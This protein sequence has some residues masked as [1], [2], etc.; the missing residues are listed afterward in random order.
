MDVYFQVHLES[1]Q[2]SLCSSS[3]GQNSSEMSKLTYLNLLI[4][5]YVWMHPYKPFMNMNRINQD[6]F[7]IF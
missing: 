3:Y 7:Y 5:I 1:H 2:N 6:L 4:S